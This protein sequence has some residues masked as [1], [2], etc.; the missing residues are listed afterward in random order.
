MKVLIPSLIL[1]SFLLYSCSDNGSR[2]IENES[3]K[4]NFVSLSPEQ[5]QVSFTN[6]INENKDLNGLTWD[7]IYSG[8]GVGI[9]DINNDGFSDLYFAGNQVSDALY[10]N[11]GDMTFTDISESSGILDH[12]GW[13]SGVSMVDINA[14]GY[15]DIYV[16][17]NSWKMDGQDPDLRRNKCFINNGNSTFSEKAQ[18][19]GIDHQSYSTQATFLDFDKDGDLDMF[20]LNTPS[21]NLKQKVDYSIKNEFPDWVSDQ[22]FI[23]NNGDFEN[24]TRQVGLEAFSFGL[25]VV[26]A[27]IDHDTWVDLYVAND[28][29]RPDY[30][31]I[32]QRDGSFRNML[33]EKVKHTS[34]TSMGC[35]A[36]D[37]NNDG[38]TDIGVVD[39]QSADHVRS[40]TNMPS[41]DEEQFWAYVK[42]GYNYQYMTNVLQVNNGAGYF[43]DI[44][45]YS[46]ISSTDWSWSILIADFDNDRNKDIFISNGINKDLRN[47]DFSAHFTKLNEEKKEIDLLELSQDLPSNPLSNFMFLNQG[48]FDFKE[49]SKDLGMATPSFS[50]GAAYGDLDND[51]DLD[52][53]VNN[54]NAPAFIYKNELAKKNFLKI[55]VKGNAKDP[56]GYGTKVFAYTNGE[57]L[58][59][60]LN[61]ARGYLSSC[62]PK[63]LLG[64]G[65]AKKSG[66]TYLH[67][68]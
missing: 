52:L 3:E 16:C 59:Q 35:D 4:G 30:M 26:A 49:S 6:H 63:I 65:N 44:A 10:L 15:L 39:M 27:D 38:L 42:K 47:N 31:Y 58:Y 40:K 14:D 34:F 1:I 8:G 54:N 45:Q 23:N 57:V 43:S 36:A 67:L 7:A 53:V 18:E 22:F 60:E 25:G 28:Y 2:Q 20:L 37:I 33:N 56:F 5:T 68:S 19:M 48:N 55:K 21:N 29:E 51:G 9:G 12:G 11:N 61:P 46:G 64:L 41:M 32:N 50:F 66:F 13:S 62:E 24:A 17:R